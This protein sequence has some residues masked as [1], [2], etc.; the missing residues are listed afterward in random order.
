VGNLAQPPQHSGQHHKRPKKRKKALGNSDFAP[1]GRI[2][3]VQKKRGETSK[4]CTGAH[5]R[6]GKKKRKSKPAV[7]EWAEAPSTRKRKKLKRQKAD[8]NQ[9]P[10]KERLRGLVEREKTSE[11]T[12]AGCGK[13]P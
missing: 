3:R 7:L 2:L 4:T 1:I 11:Q 6:R 5:C 13:K 8:S 12:G 9:V 10:G